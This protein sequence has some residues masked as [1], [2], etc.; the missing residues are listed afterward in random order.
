M[1]I[2]QGHVVEERVRAIAATLGVPE[3]VYSVPLVTKSSGVREVGDGILLCGGGGAILQV[4]ARS[5]REG[6]RDTAD[7]AERWVLKHAARAARQGV[8]S[9]RT[10]AALQRAGSP[11][12]IL[13]VR[14]L[15]LEQGDRESFQIRLEADCSFWPTIVV[16]DHPQ[17]P[18]V[19]MPFGDQA[20]YISLADWTQ[21]NRHLRSI[22]EILRY[23]RTVLAHGGSVS[24][25][26]EHECD[27]YESLV[28][29]DAQYASRVKGALGAVSFAA[30]EDPSG[31]G[32]YRRLLENTWGPNEVLPGMPIEDY[33]P[34]LDVLDDVPAVVQAYVGRWIMERRRELDMVSHRVSGSTLLVNKPLIYMCDKVSNCMNRRNW[35][36]ALGMLAALRAVEWREQR[37]ESVPVLGIGIRTGEAGDEYSYVLVRGGGSL[38]RRVR[39]PLEWEFGVANFVSF[40]TRALK[41]GRNEICPC[42]SGRKYKHCHLRIG[43]D[44]DAN[45]R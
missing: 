24:V 38:P 45:H 19:S 17:R 12:T 7:S 8:G 25:P 15:A 28:A 42:G 31:L 43:P 20:F 34:M 9:K 3:F 37:G 10:I 27:R 39:T 40:R 11:P 14:S 32:I 6:M 13:P 26:L 16:I 29:Y 41:L 1:R 23:I 30:I 44:V 5:L 22:H 2:S 36:S 18:H 33:R 35:V 21:L 4:K